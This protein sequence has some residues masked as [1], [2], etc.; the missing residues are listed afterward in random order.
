[1]MTLSSTTAIDHGRRDGA[2]SPRLLSSGTASE[3]NA[4]QSGSENHHVVF[5]LRRDQGQQRKI[6]KQVPVG[7]GSALRMLGSGGLSS[8]G[9]PA[10]Y[11][12]N[13][14]TMIRPVPTTKSRHAPSGQ[15]G[16]PVFRINSSYS[17]R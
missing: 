4:N 2:R 1:M 13:A 12:S 16:C 17:V 7:R 11:A 3:K 5:K 14:I 15:N 8:V 10:K 6:P 9:G